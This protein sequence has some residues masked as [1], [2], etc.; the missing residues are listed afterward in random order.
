MFYLY[1]G[2][3]KDLPTTENHL[4]FRWSKGDILFSVTRQGNA[5][6]IHFSASKN[7]LRKLVEAINE[8]CEYI[9]DTCDWCKMIIGTV[10][11]K[12]IIKLGDKCQFSKIDYKDKITVM[13]RKRSWD[14]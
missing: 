10:K 3:I 12:S 11:K 1:E 13:M 9:F 7:A 14:S 6:C 5:A 4:N 2:N 8:F